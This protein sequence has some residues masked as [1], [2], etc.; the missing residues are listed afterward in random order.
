MLTKKVSGL[1]EECVVSASTMF[2]FWNPTVS[3]CWRGQSLDKR[4]LVKRFHL[5]KREMIAIHKD[6][7]PDS[8]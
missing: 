4:P 5:S 3:A 6:F 1:S 2:F 7:N 8:K